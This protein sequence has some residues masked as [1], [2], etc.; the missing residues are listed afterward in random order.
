MGA[1]EN[2]N[3]SITKLHIPSLGTD[4]VL[5]NFSIS[6]ILECYLVTRDLNMQVQNN[7]RPILLYGNSRSLLYAVGKVVP[8][9]LAEFAGLLVAGRSKTLD[10]PTM[11]DAGW[12]KVEEGA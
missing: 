3:S 5:E 11:Q 7:H 9:F 4:S 12:P 1:L 10:H 8:Q 6:S 2:E